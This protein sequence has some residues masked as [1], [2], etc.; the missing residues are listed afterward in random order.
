[1]KMEANRPTLTPVF[2]PLFALL[3]SAVSHAAEKP[4]ILSLF[5]HAAVDLQPHAT[6]TKALPQETL[7]DVT[8]S[9]DYIPGA[10]SWRSWLGS[11]LLPKRKVRHDT[12][13]FRRSH[14]R[15][16]RY[17]DGFRVRPTA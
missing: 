15:F 13:T 9:L 1:M 14:H 8:G 3:L 10:P 2:I 6:A 5:A 17:S 7:V 12:E 11:M 4:N 16:G